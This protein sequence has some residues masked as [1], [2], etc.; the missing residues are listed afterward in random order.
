MAHTIGTI[1][2]VILGLVALA[3]VLNFVLGVLGIFFALIPLL[4]KLA[5][6]GG[7]IYLVWLLFHKAANAA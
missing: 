1:I 7:A 6:F 4:I 5:I 3:A 2:F